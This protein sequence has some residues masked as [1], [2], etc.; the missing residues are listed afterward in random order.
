[1]WPSKL[2]ALSPHNFIACD[3]GPSVNIFLY[4]SHFQNWKFLNSTM[5]TH[6]ELNWIFFPNPIFE[7]PA[8]ESTQKLISFHTLALKI[9]K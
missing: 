4:F 8:T 6:W 3:L 5:W 7:F 9:V 1:L 2:G